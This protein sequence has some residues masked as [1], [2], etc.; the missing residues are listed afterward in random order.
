MDIVGICARRIGESYQWFGPDKRGLYPQWMSV[1]IFT[2][3]HHPVAQTSHRYRH[4][5]TT[6]RPQAPTRLLCCLLPY[7][8]RWWWAKWIQP[9][10][11]QDG[12]PSHYRE[13]AHQLATLSSTLKPPAIRLNHSV[14]GC[15]FFARCRHIHHIH[16]ADCGYRRPWPFDCAFPNQIVCKVRDASW[17][18]DDSTSAMASA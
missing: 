13:I 8:M 9:V 2:S 3:P 16:T 11:L 17:L 7:P 6:R 12:L 18:W 10:G 4:L 14:A 15:C 5:S 1:R